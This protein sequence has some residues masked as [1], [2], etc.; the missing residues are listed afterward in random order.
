MGFDGATVSIDHL[1]EIRLNEFGDT[2]QRFT[3]ESQVWQSWE[4]LFDTVLG[5]PISALLN[6]NDGLDDSNSQGHNQLRGKES[7]NKIQITTK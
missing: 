6:W 4:V 5:P 1:L 2:G 3:I 7:T